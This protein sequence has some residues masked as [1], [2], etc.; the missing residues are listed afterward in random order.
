MQFYLNQ[1]QNINVRISQTD[2]PRQHGVA[3]QQF[4]MSGDAQEHAACA[5][6]FLL[7]QREYYLPQSAFFTKPE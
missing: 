6:E 5:V 4:P 2:C 7:Q 1:A 3:F